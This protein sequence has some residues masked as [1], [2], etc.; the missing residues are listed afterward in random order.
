MKEEYKLNSI[1]FNSYHAIVCWCK[2][3]LYTRFL[4]VLM[5][6]MSLIS[7]ILDNRVGN[8]EIGLNTF[9]LFSWVSVQINDSV[10]CGDS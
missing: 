1:L 9:Q 8:K 5:I 6:E 7:S 2:E 3:N 10:N 4:D